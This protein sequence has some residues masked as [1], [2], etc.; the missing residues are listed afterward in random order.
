ML[1]YALPLLLVS[2]LAAEEI[3]PRL[4]C[5]IS[6]VQNR[7]FSMLKTS[8]SKVENTRTQ[9]AVLNAGT[10]KEWKILTNVFQSGLSSKRFLLRNK[11]QANTP[12]GILDI[13]IW[14]GESEYQEAT[15]NNLNTQSTPANLQTDR[16]QV[17]SEIAQVLSN[18]I[19]PTT[20]STFGNLVEVTNSSSEGLNIMVY[21]V[22]DGFPGNGGSYVGGY[23]DPQDK[24]GGGGN[25]NA[26]NMLHMDIY[27]M[28]PGGLGNSFGITKK[29]FYHV[30]THELQHILH[31]QSDNNETIWVNEG[32]SQY[33]IWRVLHQTRFPLNNSII[34]DSPLDEPSQVPFWLQNPISSLLMTTDEPGLLDF[35]GPRSDSAELRGLG[36]LFFNYLW[37]RMGGQITGATAQADSAVK[38]MIQ[39]QARGRASLEAGLSGSGLDFN[40]VFRDFAVALAADQDSS[41]QVQYRLDSFSGHGNVRLSIPPVPSGDSVTVELK[42]WQFRYYQA[43]RDTNLTFSSAN[44]AAFHAAMVDNGEVLQ[45]ATAP[46]HNFTVGSNGGILVFSN[47]SVSTVQLVNG[48]VAISSAEAGSGGG[49]FIATASFGSYDSAPVRIFRDFRDRILAQS[50]WGR[51]LI[52]S[53]YRWSPALARTLESSSLGRT[54]TGFLLLPVAGLA[55]LFLSK[56]AMTI[57]FLGILGGLCRTRRLL[58]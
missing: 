34:L 56:L 2:Q 50:T 35:S 43:T 48:S 20:I 52:S 7:Y 38:L 29:D 23:F 19:L 49:C 24:F 1:R 53:Y 47:P 42:P 14:V 22:Q 36:Y 25:D 11:V 9:K 3:R 17:L 44:G 4:V 8:T 33:A 54:L 10:I 57:L 13:N 45:N 16:D 46:T 31:A 58:A 12:Q 37:Q 28:T 55:L 5:P 15:V 30:L 41:N 26:A 18:V 32:F 27:P 39:S 51:E 6:K 40:T 21:D